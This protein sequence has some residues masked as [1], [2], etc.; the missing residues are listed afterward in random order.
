MWCTVSWCG[1]CGVGYVVCSI[2]VW[3]VFLQHRSLQY[4]SVGY[5]VCNIVVRGMW[6]AV[7]RCR[8]RG[9][10]YVVC[11]MV[12][13][14]GYVVCGIMVFGIWSWP[15]GILSCVMFCVVSYVVWIMYVV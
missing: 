8:P 9:M 4:R 6:C 1:L 5:V 11:S 15:L 10:V 12:V 14:M 3:G 7:P 13:Y 2:V